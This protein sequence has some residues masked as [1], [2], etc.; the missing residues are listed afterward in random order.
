MKTE[1]RGRCKELSEAAAAEDPTLTVTKGWYDD[2]LWGE[3]EHWWCTR[4]DGTIVD[5]TAAQFPV[6]GVA[7]L[8]R[9]YVGK[10]PCW[11]C[12]TATPEADLVDGRFCSGRC[13]CRCVGVPYHEGSDG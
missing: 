9:P 8:Y 4:P 11:E 7:S 3:Q 2:P 10:Y 13:A 12:G 5:P 1:L 6:G